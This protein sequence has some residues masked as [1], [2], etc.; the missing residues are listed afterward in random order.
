MYYI[1]I[2]RCK[3]NSLYTGITNNLE[4]RIEEH[5]NR[6]KRCAKYTKNHL[7]IKLEASCKT[8]DRKLASKLEYYIKH[9]PK[10]EK[11]DI[12]KHNKNITVLSEKLDITSYKRIRLKG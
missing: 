12:I 10:S 7:D 11:E 2:I 6:T 3:D 1:Y 8:E 5:I 9:L 4:R